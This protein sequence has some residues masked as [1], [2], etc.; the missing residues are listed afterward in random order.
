MF[1]IEKK[2]IVYRAVNYIQFRY[3]VDLSVI[4]FVLRCILNVF[5]VI[6]INTRL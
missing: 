4:D 5:C 6:D 2:S 3:Q 1:D